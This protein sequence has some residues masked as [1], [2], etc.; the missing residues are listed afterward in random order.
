[1]STSWPGELKLRESQKQNKVW[2]VQNPKNQ[3]QAQQNT[4]ISQQEKL[5]T[6][7]YRFGK[8]C[9]LLHKT[10]WLGWGPISISY[11]G[12]EIRAD[13]LKTLILPISVC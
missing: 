8:I 5:N 11:Y 13:S 2:V 1:M 9:Y 3:R 7:V 6:T 4:T 10:R 12:T